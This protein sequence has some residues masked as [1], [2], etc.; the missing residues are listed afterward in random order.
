[1]QTPWPGYLSR[2]SLSR[3]LRD[4][5]WLRIVA[6]GQI[7]LL[8]RRH[9]TKLDAGERRHLADLVRRARSLTPD[10]RNELKDLVAKLEPGVFAGAAAQRFSPVPGSAPLLIPRGRAGRPPP[11]HRAPRVARVRDV[12]PSA[13]ARVYGDPE[14][15]RDVGEGR[16][17][18]A[19]IVAQM[20]RAAVD[21]Q[22]AHGYSV[23]A[24]LERESGELIGD[25]GLYRMGE[26]VELG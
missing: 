12:G 22:A 8:A 18:D 26:E 20:V 13:I 7:A 4:L 9:L 17:A 19:A 16:P 11:A 2:V 23:W 1:M 25:A 6:I 5:P 14:V 3:R 24:L 21:H 10:E 15:M